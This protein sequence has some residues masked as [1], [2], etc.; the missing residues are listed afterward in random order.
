MTYVALVRIGSNTRL[1]P[2]WRSKSGA[3]T[4][5]TNDFLIEDDSIMLLSN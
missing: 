4:N 1:V 3:I 2:E 5:I